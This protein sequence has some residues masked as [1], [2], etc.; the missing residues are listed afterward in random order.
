MTTLNQLHQTAEALTLHVFQNEFD[1][2]RE[3]SIYRA[4]L[5]NKAARTFEAFEMTAE[6]TA[7][8]QLAEHVFIEDTTEE[9]LTEAFTVINQLNG[10]IGRNYD[11]ETLVPAILWLQLIGEANTAILEVSDED[12]T[13]V[14]RLDGNFINGTVNQIID[15]ILA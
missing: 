13:K 10:S 14:A 8:D 6:A 1:T 12:E 15:T 7:L 11:T 3:L 4:G 5:L 2:H 9:E